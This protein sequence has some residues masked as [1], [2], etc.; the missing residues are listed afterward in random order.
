MEEIIKAIL[1][2][3]VGAGLVVAWFVLIGKGY[4]D[5]QFNKNLEKYKGEIENDN[6]QK[7]EVLKINLN[8][9]FQKEIE[10]F[11]AEIQIETALNERRKFEAFNRE[12]EALNN[13]RNHLRNTVSKIDIL[14]RPVKISGSGI[15]ASEAVNE[16]LNCFE[17]NRAFLSKET[18]IIL[19]DAHAALSSWASPDLSI[20]HGKDPSNFRWWNSP[21]RKIYEAIDH[22]ENSIRMK[23]RD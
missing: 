19:D 14:K 8:K 1:A 4:I 21:Q 16:F 3:G 22:L 11:K 23:M 6:A 9:E 10:K 13:L 2:G 18:T 7:I 15:D 5:H 17:N 12:I 20:E